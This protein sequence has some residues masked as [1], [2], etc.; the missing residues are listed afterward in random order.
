MG[1]KEYET[2]NYETLG[3]PDTPEMIYY[4]NRFLTNKKHLLNLAF[5][6]L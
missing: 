2:Q 3:S 6:A 4:R 1:K 5:A